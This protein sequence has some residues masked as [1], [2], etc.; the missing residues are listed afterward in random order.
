M[1]RINARDAWAIVTDNMNFMYNQIHA[2]S[3][4]DLPGGVVKPGPSPREYNNTLV[5]FDFL[6]K[7]AR[8]FAPHK[9]SSI[10][11]LESLFKQVAAGKISVKSYLASIK[12]IASKNGL[13]TNLIRFMESRIRVQQPI[14]ANKPKGPFFKLNKFSYAPFSFGPA[15]RSKPVKS[16]NNNKV[17]FMALDLFLKRGK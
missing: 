3:F 2:S 4:V 7:S 13:D 11:R 17:P 14:V 6:K 9:L 10:N 8:S 5:R 16:R 12:S 15:K 1:V